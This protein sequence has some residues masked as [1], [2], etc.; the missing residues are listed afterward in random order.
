MSGRERSRRTRNHAPG[1]FAP[2]TDREALHDTVLDP[3]CGKPPGDRDGRTGLVV[4]PD[5]GSA[6]DEPVE[7]QVNGFGPFGLN[8]INPDDDPGHDAGEPG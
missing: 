4:I 1:L 8:D 5:G 3:C 6:A 2:R 7:L